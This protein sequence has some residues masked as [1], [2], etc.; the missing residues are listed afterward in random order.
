MCGMFLP[1]CLIADSNLGPFRLK[2]MFLKG[3]FGTSEELI[4]NLK[5]NP[6]VSSWDTVGSQNMTNVMGL[7]GYKYRSSQTQLS[8]QGNIFLTEYRLIAH[9]I[10]LHESVQLGRYALISAIIRHW[11]CGGV[12][13][14]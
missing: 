14:S 2:N 4:D 9:S 12:L 7:L 5:Q 10:V 8:Y 3:S 6:D 1:T 11:R 13:H